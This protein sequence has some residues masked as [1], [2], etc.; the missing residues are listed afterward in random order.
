MQ[1]FLPHKDFG[2]SARCLD[3]Q[4]LG[5]QRVE[6]LQILRALRGYT[7]GW[8]NHPAVK[9][10]RGYEVALAWYG[11]VI[12]EE[13]V[14]RGFRDTCAAKIRRFLPRP[15][16]SPYHVSNAVVH[17]YLHRPGARPPWLGSRKFHNSHRSNLLRKDPIYYSKFRWTVS[18][19]LPYLWPEGAAA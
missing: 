8:R 11:L 4:R 10:W 18:D 13:W 14:R 1:T 15:L 12:C 5:K 7:K 3:N 17:Y 9:M 19:D 2:K 16:R 6:V